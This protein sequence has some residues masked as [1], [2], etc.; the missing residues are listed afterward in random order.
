MKQETVGKKYKK[1]QL[2]DLQGNPY[3][4]KDG[5]IIEIIGTNAEG[6]Y[7]NPYAKVLGQ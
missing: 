3:K 6:A 2:T 4:L 5:D 1:I 7:T